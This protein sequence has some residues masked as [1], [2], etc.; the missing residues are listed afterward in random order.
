SDLAAATTAHAAL[1]RILPSNRPV[2]LPAAPH[3][4][5]GGHSC[6]PPAP[7][8][9]ADSPRTARRIRHSRDYLQHSPGRRHS[10]AHLRHQ[11]PGTVPRES[12]YLSITCQ[13]AHRPKKPGCSCRF[14]HPA[15]QPQSVRVVFAPF[16]I[17]G[18][19]G[20]T[21]L[22]AAWNPMH[23]VCLW[24]LIRQPRMSAPLHATALT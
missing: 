13:V 20:Q 8:V 17:A 15:S 23:E 24:R 7:A 22:S 18:T 16:I 21:F 11:P 12:A 19:V 10:P 4:S 14:A 2:R 9:A 1:A 6:L 5:S 3:P